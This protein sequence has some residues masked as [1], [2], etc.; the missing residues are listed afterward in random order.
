MR[1]LLTVVALLT[2]A[3]APE[4]PNVA[5]TSGGEVEA[6][7]A[8]AEALTA[9]CNSQSVCNAQ[10]AFVDVA[11]GVHWSWANS[12]CGTSV[13]YWNG[14]GPGGRVAQSGLVDNNNIYQRWFYLSQQWNSTVIH[15]T[16]P[17]TDAPNCHF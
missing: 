12:P 4:M 1:T 7:G 14:T 8:K 10:K 3:C 17:A 13:G 6:A 5:E 9:S 16:C 11:S 15:C 2:A